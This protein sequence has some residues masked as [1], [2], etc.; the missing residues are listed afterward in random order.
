MGFFILE[1]GYDNLEIF[2]P[3]FIRG[4]N[5]RTNLNSAANVCSRQFTKGNC[6][7]PPIYQVP[8][9]WNSLPKYKMSRY[10]QWELLNN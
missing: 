10:A 6:K 7:L 1:N 3:L 2:K 5:S 8:K 4:L 9:L